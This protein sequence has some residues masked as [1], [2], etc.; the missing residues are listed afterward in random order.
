M[1]KSSCNERW[2]Q[3]GKNWGKLGNQFASKSGAFPQ[4]PVSSVPI[5]TKLRSVETDP[6]RKALESVAKQ[7]A[8]PRKKFLALDPPR[9]S[10]DL[11]LADIEP[12]GRPPP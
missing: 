8:K 5:G 4:S 7:K 1:T 3:L 10:A 2:K 9:P 12:P 6:G 11:A